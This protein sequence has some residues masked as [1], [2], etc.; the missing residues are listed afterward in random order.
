M[1]LFMAVQKWG[2]GSIEEIN[3]KEHKDSSDGD[4]QNET[5]EFY[6]RSSSICQLLRARTMCYYSLFCLAWHYISH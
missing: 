1:V 5:E 6:I 3:R 2:R 4:A